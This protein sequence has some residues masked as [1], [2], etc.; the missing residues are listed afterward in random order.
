MDEISPPQKTASQVSLR[1]PR[2][3]LPAGQWHPCPPQISM[4][5]P[6]WGS[7]GVNNHWDDS[8]GIV[9]GMSMGNHHLIAD[10]EKNWI[11]PPFLFGKINHEWTWLN[12]YL[13]HQSHQRLHQNGN[14]HRDTDFLRL[15]KNRPQGAETW[16]HHHFPMSFYRHPKSHIAGYTPQYISPVSSVFFTKEAMSPCRLCTSTRFLTHHDFI[17]SSIHWILLYH[18]ISRFSHIPLIFTS[19]PFIMEYHGC[20][21][22]QKSPSFPNSLHRWVLVKNLGQ[23]L[24]ASQNPVTLGNLSHS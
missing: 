6:T 3:N 14:F 17:W 8:S 15:T 12:S 2:C 10:I 7:H 5:S 18:I 22:I 20:N 21:T 9:I 4:A 23:W 16:F 24:D 1:Y 13:N 19:I 11:S